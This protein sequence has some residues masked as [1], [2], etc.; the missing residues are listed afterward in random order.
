MNHYEIAIVTGASSGIGREI[1][2]LLQKEEQLELWLVA[3]RKDRLEELSRELEAAGHKVRI[4]DF[5][6][7]DRNSWSSLEEEL[8]ASGQ[9]L[10]WLVNN[11]GFGF[12]GPLLQE[13]VD[14]VENMITLNVMALSSLTRRLLP[15][16]KKG[17]KIVN[18]ASSIAF[19][20]GPYYTV[21]AA[22]KAYVL[23]FS[24]GLATELE[25][26]GI[27]VSAVCPGPVATEFFDSNSAKPPMSFGIEDAKH[28][29]FLSVEQ[30]AQGNA[31]IVTG[32][33]AW[34][35]RIVSAILPRVLLAKMFGKRAKL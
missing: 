18:I 34:A 35:L 24:L 3:R 9:N 12:H 25:P 28:T 10:R 7:L 23:S 26:L 13:S 15:F 30:A 16:M 8:K 4:F 19:V 33:L 6:L 22:T 1:A 11:A 20:P 32:V 29:A 31:I 5:D 2:R 21:Y 17:S 14:H 27:T